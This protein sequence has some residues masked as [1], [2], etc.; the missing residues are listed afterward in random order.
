VADFAEQEVGLRP[1]PLAKLLGEERARAL[2][3]GEARL[4]LWPHRHGTDGF[5]VAVFEKPV[6]ASAGPGRVFGEV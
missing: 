1:A 5:F 2:G 3:A 6:P 4:Q